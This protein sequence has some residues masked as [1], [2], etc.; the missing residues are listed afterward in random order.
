MWVKRTLLR[1][2]QAAVLVGLCVMMMSSGAEAAINPLPTPDPQSSS[3]GI[4]TTKRQP[5]PTTGATI[6]TPGSGA[7]YSTSPITVSGMCPTGLLVQ[8]YNNGV[9]AGAVMCS[10]GSFT[11]QV[12]LFRGQNDIT[13]AVF[14]DL[15]QTGPAS[16]TASVT[17]NDPAFSAF[18]AVM[19]LSS[20]F[21]R[22]A[23]NPDTELT[24]PLLLSGGSGPYAFSID[25]G[26]GTSPQLKSQALAGEINI[27]HTYK[28]AGVYRVVV[29]ATDANGVTVFL[30]LVAIANGKVAVTDTTA[31]KTKTVTVVR[32]L[33]LPVA[34]VC[35][36][37]F[38]AF[39]LG[40][41]SQLVS[42][43]KRM[44]KS[45]ENYKEL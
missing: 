8:V 30:Q 20:N 34:I 36:L 11:M 28:K 1:Y 17:Y 24:W 5:P 13:A 21:G 6:T 14:D 39:W 37:L 4:E 10:N 42:L 15:D 38:P 41:R 25:W 23:A 45:L 3:Y 26:D 35:A 40:R 16:N 31:E 29:R 27:A 44:E 9:L 18:G 32:V 43:H 33:W 2:T 12:S 22:R 19:T 7:S